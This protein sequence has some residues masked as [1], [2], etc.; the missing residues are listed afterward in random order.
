VVGGGKV[1]D[2]KRK[3]GRWSVERRLEFIDFRLYWEGHIN[4]S[5][6]V[7]FFEISVPQASADLTKYQ[8]AAKGNAEYDKYAKTYKAGPRFKPKFFEPS[9]DQYFAQLRMIQSG[10]LAEA[11]AWAVR[12]PS[13]SIV[14]ILRRRLD[15]EVLRSILQA[16]RAGT[17]VEVEYQSFTHSEPRRRWISPHALAFDGSRWHARAWCH[18][19]RDFRDFVLARILELCGVGKPES[20]PAHDEGWHREVLLRIGPHPDLKGGKRR[21]IELDYGLTDGVVEI[22][23]RLCLSSY[24]ERHLGL[25]LD[26]AHVPPERQQ[27]VLLNREEVRAARASAAFCA[28]EK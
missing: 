15:P 8:E 20:D 26:P 10:L 2:R 13:Y 5:D 28:P 21:A 14:P 22:K 25:D 19:R 27:I 7:A 12:L 9:A 16:I 4:R 3:R 18:T 23:T 11:E 24:F 17:S 6:L 1:A